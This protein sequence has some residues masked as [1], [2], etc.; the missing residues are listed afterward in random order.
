MDYK[1][2]Q[3]RYKQAVNDALSRR[4]FLGLAGGAGLGL[5]GC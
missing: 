4:S 5:A 3:R 2:D 1:L